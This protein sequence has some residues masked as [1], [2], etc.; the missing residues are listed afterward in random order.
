MVAPVRS[1]WQTTL[2]VTPGIILLLIVA[3]VVTLLTERISV[4]HPVLLAIITGFIIGNLGLVP[5]RYQ[6]GID[7]YRIWLAAAIIL[8][9]AS[10]SVQDL[11]EGGVQLFGIVLGMVTIGLL[12]TEYISRR[13]FDVTEPLGSL[14]AAGSSICGVSAVVA[15]A[16]SIRAKENYIAYAAGVVVLFDGITVILFPIIGRLLG[17]TDIQ[18]GV[19]VGVSMFSTG[20]VIAAGFVHSE[21]AGQWATLTKIMRNSL[22]GLVVVAYTVM[23]AASRGDTA[24]PDAPV[25]RQRRTQWVLE[26]LWQDSPKFI[27]GFVFMIVL[28]STGI[29][30]TTQTQVIETVYGWL[31]LIAF[32]GLGFE[33]DLDRIRNT[34]IQPII[35]IFLSLVLLSS[36]AFAIVSI[37]L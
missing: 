5:P 18:Y 1:V 30:T 20:P 33:I 14:L 24:H 4:I 6:T 37:L 27:I 17:L 22:I 28:A 8:M 31:F 35:V 10:F 16:T 12:F 25:S 15:V 11:L 3:S 32:V 34:G 2:A 29:F 7:T 23:Y 19:W 9:G 36:I 21:L 26:K 13:L